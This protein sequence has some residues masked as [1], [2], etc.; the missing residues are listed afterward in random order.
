[1]IVSPEKA[2]TNMLVSIAVSAFISTLLLLF[3]LTLFH[4]SVTGMVASFPFSLVLFA[5][6]YYFFT[7]KFRRRKRL[8]RLPFPGEWKTILKERVTFYNGLDGQEK[9][10]FRQEVRIFLS[11][12][13]ITGIKTEVDDTTRILVAA[14]AVI[15][16]FGFPEW[17]FDRLGEVLI[18]PSTFDDNYQFDDGKGPISG[19]VGTRGALHGIMILS[20]P[21]LFKGFQDM[22]DRDNVG[23]HEFA[24]LVDAKDG[25]TDGIPATLEVGLVRP[26]LDLIDREIEAIRNRKSDIRPYGATNRTEFFAVVSEYFFETPALLERKHPE[27]YEMLR[28]IFRQDMKSRIA[29]ALKSMISP[30]GKRIGRNDPCPCGKGRKYKHCC[31]GKQECG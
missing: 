9:E 24:H 10:R 15:P 21:Q 3:C 19:L 27:L 31:L 14:S 18:Y 5:I 12:V 1:M 7:R 4:D 28:K 22:C 17:E 20:K 29:T 13:R 23:I 16:I 2:R 25:S 26:W 11:E 8:M 30:Y 6:L